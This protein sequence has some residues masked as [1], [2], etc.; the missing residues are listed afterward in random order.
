MVE[1]ENNSEVIKPRKKKGVTFDVEEM[2]METDKSY[3]HGGVGIHRKINSD[4]MEKVRHIFIKA[5]S[6]PVAEYKFVCV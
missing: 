2:D 5:V 6:F 3:A 1:D 4:K